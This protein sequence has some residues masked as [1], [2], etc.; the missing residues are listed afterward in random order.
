[1]VGPSPSSASPTSAAVLGL[2]IGPAGLD[3]AVL[4][5][6]GSVLASH[7]RAYPGD[8]APDRPGN[9][10]DWWRAVRTGVKDILRRAGIDASVV[11]AV[12]VAGEHA[13]LAVDRHGEALA[14][15]VLG[16][17]R[18]D[19]AGLEALLGA[20]G[21]RTLANLTGGPADLR[22]ALVQ[23]LALRERE[24]RAWHDLR[25]LLTPK[26]YIRLRLTSTIGTDPSDAALSLLFNPRTRTWSRQL[27]TLLGLDPTLLPT[28]GPSH[29]LAGRVT[30]IAA[31][32]AGLV[33]GT[34]VV[35]GAHRLAAMAIAAGAT[36]PG[37]AVLELG[38]AGGLLVTTAEPLRD[39]EGCFALACG[40]TPG[41]ATLVTADC[42]GGCATG[43]V[44]ET[45]LSELTAQAR[46]QGRDPLL[47]LAETAADAPAGADGLRWRQDAGGG[48][49]IGLRPHHGRA[50]VARAAIEGGALAARGLLQRAIHLKAPVEH[51]HVAGSGAAAPL[52]CQVVAD[53][54][55]LTVQA[56]T[57]PEA[58]ALGAGLLAASAVGLHKKS[59]VL[60]TPPWHQT[61]SPRKAAVAHYLDD[62]LP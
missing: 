27:M 40:A 42:T 17:D 39:P 14:D 8:H 6:D 3:L 45:V 57:I 50:H 31:R 62:P 37:H 30:D 28:V 44:L 23:L 19:Q 49:L 25:H 60:K 26:D 52:W 4:G 13:G 54:T 5:A 29:S 18:R 2:D 34:P 12:G 41:L 15:A 9:P 59:S 61:W 55:G 1:M 35:T 47:A 56:V 43:W 11:R 32:E 58:G 33:A 10:A 16:R 21:A 46:R 38:G 53:V 36:T 24:K 51:L 22:C 7:R 48:T 20:V